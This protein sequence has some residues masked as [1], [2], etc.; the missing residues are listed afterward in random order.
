M[1]KDDKAPD[2]KIATPAEKMS[3]IVLTPEEKEQLSKGTDIKIVLDVKDVSDTVSSG[4]KALAEAALSGDGAAKGFAISQYLDISL[5]KVIGENRNAISETK[6]KIALALAVPDSLKN[7]DSKKTRTFAVL[8]IHDG[9][10]ELLNDVDDNA[11]T[12]TI[13]TDRFATY[14]I[15]Y[16]DASNGGSSDN[17]GN[18]ND[19]KDN[20]DVNNKNDNQDNTNNNQNGVNDNKDN[21]DDNKNDINDNEDDDS[22]DIDDDDDSDSGDDGDDSSSGSSGSGSSNGSGPETGDS[23]PIEFYATLSIIAGFTWLLL[24]FSDRKRGMTEETKKRLV[25]RIV[26]WAKRGSKIRKYPAIAVIFVL[27]VYYHSIG[28][29]TCGE[30]EEICGE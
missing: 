23:A 13:E 4:D 19:N 7:T 8:R 22:E 1:Q 2:T 17:N 20:Q 29:K 30:W 24:Y 14:A 11:D 26:A 21:P 6:E 3:D 9:K 15:V 12:I 16:K 27:L 5:F 28:K 25:S 18:G 10:A